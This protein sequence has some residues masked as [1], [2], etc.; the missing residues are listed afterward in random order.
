MSSKCSRTRMLT[1]P[2]KASK[3]Q[4]RFRQSELR[5]IP[6]IKRSENFLLLFT[7]SLPPTKV[8]REKTKTSKWA[9]MSSKRFAPSNKEQSTSKMVLYQNGNKSALLRA[10]A[11]LCSKKSETL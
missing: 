8:L 10:R 1:G 5:S 11:F 9:S 7:C 6:E 2:R 3:Y 4:S